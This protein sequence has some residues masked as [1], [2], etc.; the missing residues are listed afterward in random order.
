MINQSQVVNPVHVMHPMVVNQP[1]QVP[2][3]VNRSNDIWMPPGP[4]SHSSIESMKFSNGINREGFAGHGY[5]HQNWMDRRRRETAGMKSVRLGHGVG[6]GPPPL[7][8]LQTRNHRLKARRFYQNKKFN[9]KRSAPYAPRNTTSFL[10]RAKRSGGI[11]DLVSPNPVT[12]S[13]L[14]T[15]QLSPS[16]ELLGDMV[17]E[18]W[19]VDGYGSMNGL[20]R[21]KSPEHLYED[22]DDGGLSSD[23][24]LE[25]HVEM[26][27]KLDHDLSRFEMIYPNY[28]SSH[29]A[30]LEN[31]V[32]DQDNH[33]SELEQE[34]MLLREKLHSMENE[35]NDLRKLLQNLEN[36][37]PSKNGIDEGYDDEDDAI[38]EKNKKMDG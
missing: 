6:Y 14:S 37:N 18:K 10:I 28:G 21:L 13:I 35:M 31:R 38:F 16:R 29:N 1:P 8:D 34:N 25:E 23:S 19:G 30:I 11:A 9:D 3:M 5:M 22:E 24:D 4:R 12:P 15:P 20:I 2:H 17:K 27:K 36:R 32:S 33:I 7:N 26:E